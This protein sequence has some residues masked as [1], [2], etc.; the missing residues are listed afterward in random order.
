MWGNLPYP[1]AIAGTVIA[2]VAAFGIKLIG[3]RIIKST[4]DPKERYRRYKFLNTAITLVFVAAMII[5][6]GRLFHNKGTFFGLIGAGLAIALKEPLLSVAG[7]IAI[8]A[9]HM[10]SVGDRIEINKMSGDVID[11]GMFYTRMMEIGNW[12]T[13][14][15]ATG[16]IVQIPNSQIFGTPVFNYTQNFAYIWDQVD[17][18]IS[19]DSNAEAGGKIMS[20]AGN[21]YT[22][23]FLKKA[24]QDLDEMR[25]SFLVPS[26]ELKPQVYMTFDSNYVT[27]TMRYIVDPH[28]RRAAK[29]YLFSQML[30]KI[31]ER[32]DIHF[33]STTMDLTLHG[34]LDEGPEVGQKAA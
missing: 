10:Y 14:D 7:R 9:G 21:D 26:F 2:I 13:A 5:L 1:Y 3:D 4:K 15:Q 27:L 20:E 32:D 29:S 25:H 24:E 33:G 31:K 12:I 34:Q 11:V 30:K 23:E 18:P 22:K 28:Q 19:Y 17:L 16:R 8:F 6:W